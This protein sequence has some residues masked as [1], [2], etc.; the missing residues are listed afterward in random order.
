MGMMKIFSL[1]LCLVYDTEPAKCL[2]Y[3]N[4]EAKGTWRAGF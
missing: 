1:S 4:K 3:G 2:N